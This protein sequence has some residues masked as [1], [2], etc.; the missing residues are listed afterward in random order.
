[1]FETV[2]VFRPSTQYL[3]ATVVAVSAGML[4]QCSSHSAD[5]GEHGMAG[6]GGLPSSTPMDSAINFDA[7][8]VVNGEDASLT[9]IN[10][11]TNQTAGTI[12]LQNAAFPH[13]LYLSGDRQKM[14]LAVPGMDLSGGHDVGMHAM[15][16]AVML[17]DPL[18][19]ATLKSRVFDNMNHNA[20]FSPNGAE[21]WTSQMTSSG[22]VLVLDA[23]TLETKQTISVGAL[24]AE[25]TFS[26]DG[27]NAFVANGGSASV[28][29]IDAATKAVVKTI[30]VG[31]DPVGA[32][33]GSN[34]LAYVDNEKAMTLSVIDTK[35]LD[36]TLTYNL[37]FMPGM[38]ALAPDG[39]LW[40]TDADNGKLVI[41]AADRDM[42]IADVATGTGAHA[43]AF[44]GDKKTGYVT[45][46]MA[47]TI[48]VIDVA[49]HDMK[50]LPVGKKPNGM[51]WRSK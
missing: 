33:Q 12:Q 30:T 19:G 39:N 15:P 13:H 5:H 37:G 14:A 27:K 28:S 3:L 21:I 23:T 46:Q 18:T 41:F 34:G 45:N 32:W 50:T 43:I 49:T 1:M 4:A 11:E 10:T 51:A 16:G 47:A 8:Y 29:V 6:D 7:L 24:P 2:S 26:L 42:K 20:V 48:S 44:S 9:V 35:T 25:V 38:A 40:V 36:V 22:A 17:L 31:E